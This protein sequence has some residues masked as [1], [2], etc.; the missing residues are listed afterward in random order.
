MFLSCALSVFIYQS[1]DAI[2]GKQA[3]RTK[4][5]NQ[6]GELFDHGCDAVSNI[7]LI[8]CCGGAAALNEQPNLFLALMAIQLCL[9]YCYHWLNYV[10]GELRFNW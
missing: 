10:V 1:L 6:L 2:D 8:P 3:R 7:L 5:N 4:T 9:F